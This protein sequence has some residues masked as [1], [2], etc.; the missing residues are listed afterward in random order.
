M[1]KFKHLAIAALAVA[2]I[3]SG[4]GTNGGLSERPRRCPPGHLPSAIR[5]R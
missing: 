1:N 4:C 2:T 5:V 3:V